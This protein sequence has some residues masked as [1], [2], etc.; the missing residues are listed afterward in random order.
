MNRVLQP[1]VMD[2]P[3]LEEGRHRRAL[4]GLTRLNRLSGSHSCYGPASLLLY[5][6]GFSDMESLLLHP[7]LKQ[8][9]CLAD[10]FLDWSS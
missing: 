9:E 1:E 7:G 5:Y 10:S 8:L 2:D 4:D 3:S 6:S